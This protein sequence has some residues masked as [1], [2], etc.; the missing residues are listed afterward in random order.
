MKELLLHHDKE[1]EVV[2]ENVTMEGGQVQGVAGR[3]MNPGHAI[4][5]GWFLLQHATKNG[6]KELAETAVH[7]FI[8]TPLAYGWDKEWGGIM[9]FMDAEGGDKLFL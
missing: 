9:Y 5:C 7:S 3:M 1:R 8:E 2:L 4:E 6:D